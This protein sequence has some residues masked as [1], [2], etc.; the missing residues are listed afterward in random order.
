MPWVDELI[1]RLGR[2]TYLF[3]LNLT[4]GYWQ[5]PLRDV[6]NEKTA[7]TTPKGLYQFTYMPFDLQGAAATFQ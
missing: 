1:E 2:A 6:Y 4:K 3:S 5:I 7:F